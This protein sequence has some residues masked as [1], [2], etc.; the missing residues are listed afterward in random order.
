MTTTQFNR[1]VVATGRIYRRSP[2]E[3]ALKKR[4]IALCKRAKIVRCRF[5][6]PEETLL[7]CPFRGKPP[8]FD[9]AESR[10]TWQ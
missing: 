3:R 8:V 6:L 2:V 4:L 7:L 1:I 5:R 9:G 10:C